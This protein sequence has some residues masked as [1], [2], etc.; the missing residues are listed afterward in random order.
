MEAAKRFFNQAVTMV[1][2]APKRVTTDG[3]DS[4]PRAIRETLGDTVVHRTNAYLNNRLEQDHRGIK[5][6]YSP[7]HGFGSFTSA[8]RFCRAFN[9]GPQFFRFRTTTKQYISLADQRRLF[10]QRL[11]ALKVMLLVA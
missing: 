11:D 5:Q 4:S 7:M 6:R 8:S 10:C 1:D 2:H 3:H 9:E